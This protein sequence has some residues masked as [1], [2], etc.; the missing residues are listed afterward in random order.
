MTTKASESA[1]GEL[2]AAVANALIG[3]I[4]AKDEAGV[5]LCTAAHLGAAI[6]F[7]KNNNITADPDTNKGLTD[8]R[9]ALQR[10]R[11]DAKSSMAGKQRA[12]EDLERTLSGEIPGLR[13]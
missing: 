1:L 7:L 11:L 6:A 13:Q 5:P 4:D 8:L 9:D 10:K 2:H 12:A 3:V